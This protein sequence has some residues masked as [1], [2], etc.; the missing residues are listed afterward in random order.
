MKKCKSLLQSSSVRASR[1]GPSSGSAPS[2]R[3][4]KVKRIL[5]FNW[6]IIT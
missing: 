3:N 1:I 4:K 5:E 2:A 6:D